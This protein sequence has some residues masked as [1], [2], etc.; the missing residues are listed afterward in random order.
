MVTILI[1]KQRFAEMAKLI[2]P[3]VFTM[4][5]LKA[6][7]EYIDDNPFQKSELI[8]ELLRPWYEY[9]SIEEAIADLGCEDLE[10]LKDSNT[11]VEIP[12]TSRVLVST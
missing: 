3:T 2:Y 1:D 6:L 7:Y 8:S 9:D 11:V 5:G 12:E 4:D 10:D